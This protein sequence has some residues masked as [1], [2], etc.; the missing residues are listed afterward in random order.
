MLLNK[1]SFVFLTFM[2]MPAFAFARF[3]KS[4]FASFWDLFRSIFS[5]LFLGTPFGVAFI[6]VFRVRWGSFPSTIFVISFPISLFF[7][8]MADSLILRLA[9]RIRK[10]VIVIGK[11]RLKEAPNL[12]AYLS[13]FC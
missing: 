5:G 7:I 6:Y 13:H 8:Y 3:F 11:E 4:R 12:K 2:Y 9:G 1:D 10:K